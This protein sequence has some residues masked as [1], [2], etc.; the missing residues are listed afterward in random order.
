MV[1]APLSPVNIFA[2][3]VMDW[4]APGL[5]TPSEKVIESA[6]LHIVRGLTREEIA[7]WRDVSIKTVDGQMSRFW[8]M[9]APLAPWL[10]A[11]SRGRSSA[12]WELAAAYWYRAG[13]RDADGPPFRS[14]AEVLQEVPS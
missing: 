2:E 8:A 9:A 14:R 3:V 10:P 6:F 4:M 12:R 11:L 13:Q 1:E 7:K 5:K